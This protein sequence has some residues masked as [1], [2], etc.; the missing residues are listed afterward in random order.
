MYTFIYCFVQDGN[1]VL[2]TAAFND[3]EDIVK[4]M[5]NKKAEYALVDNQIEIA[6]K[7]LLVMEICYS[8]HHCL[9]IIPGISPQANCTVLHHYIKVKNYSMVELLLK[10]FS[11]SFKEKV[12]VVA[13]ICF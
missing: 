3:H 1:T 13:N 5:I 6:N 10:S 8:L 9:V 2:H 7:V 12:F 11:E 4:W